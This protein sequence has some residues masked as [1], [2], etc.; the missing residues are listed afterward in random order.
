MSHL[1]GI[2]KN[3]GWGTPVRGVHTHTYM[4]LSPMKHSHM[5]KENKLKNRWLDVYHMGLDYT[6]THYP[7]AYS[8]TQDSLPRRAW[9]LGAYLEFWG[10]LVSKQNNACPLPGFVSTALELLTGCLKPKMKLCQLAARGRTKIN[11]VIWLQEAWKIKFCHLAAGD[12][13]NEILLLD[14]VRCV[15]PRHWIPIKIS[16]NLR[17]PWLPKNSFEANMNK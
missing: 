12:Q 5:R 2:L 13:K 10:H 1:H 17:E 8:V 4:N 14:C 16:I 7:S 3:D 15:P 11:S 6:S 9:V